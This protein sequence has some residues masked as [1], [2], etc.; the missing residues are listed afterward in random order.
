MGLIQVV[1]QAT[2]DDRILDKFFTNRPDLFNQREVVVSLI[3]IKRR[4][5]LINYEGELCSNTIASISTIDFYDIRKP[6]IDLL[7]SALLSYNWRHLTI[8]NNLDCMYKAFINVIEWHINKYIPKI[9]ITVSTK[10]PTFITPLSKQLLRKRNKLMRRVLSIKAG[11]IAEKTRRSI[12][13][14]R[15]SLLADVDNRSTNQLWATV[16]P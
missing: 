12:A 15:R 4:A 7:N 11:E 6:Y 14:K 2:H 9:H 16:T 8:D 13:K 5:V 1:T 10:L 3:Q